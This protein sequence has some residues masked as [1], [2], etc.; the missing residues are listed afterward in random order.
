MLFLK[1]DIF[2]LGGSVTDS[3]VQSVVM[4]GTCLCPRTGLCSLQREMRQEGAGN[5]LGKGTE[6]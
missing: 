5:K 4:D 2:L 3:S 1:E 6:G